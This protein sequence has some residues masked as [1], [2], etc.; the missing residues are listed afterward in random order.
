MTVTHKRCYALLCA[1]DGAAFSGFQ[2]QPPLPTVQGALEDALARLG[3]KVQIE[4]GG[5]TDAGVHARRQVVTFR[6]RELLN[7]AELQ[8]E[9]GALL[10]EALR[11]VDAREAPYSFH[12]RF[13][14]VGKIYRYCVAAMP[15][16]GE[17][18][19]R[20]CWTLP[21]PRGF[22]DL[23]GPVERLDEESM[24]RVLEALRGWHDFRLLAHPKTFGKTRRLLMEA[25]LRIRE[26]E[27]GRIYELTFSSPG[28][29]RHQVRNLVGVAVTAGLGRLPE[30]ELER[31]LAAKGDRWRG[32]RAPGRG[33]CLWDIR[34]RDGEDPFRPELRADD[35]REEG[36]DD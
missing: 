35:S 28:F 19:R 33:L 23:E 34:Y 21:D 8:R 13:S 9:L 5:R 2:R 7:P 17:N 32:V 16:P 20:F 6:A 12:A 18:E 1:Y 4:G 31:L 29:L 3:L 26:A 22:P 27:V 14:A 15:A 10:P 30:G 36:R 25:R 11:I 24:R